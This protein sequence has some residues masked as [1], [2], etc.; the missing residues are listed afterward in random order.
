MG[1]ETYSQ[2]YNRALAEELEAVGLRHKYELRLEGRNDKVQHL[3]LEG[4][5]WLKILGIGLRKK[6]IVVGLITKEPNLANIQKIPGLV[7]DS[8]ECVVLDMIVKDR[9]LKAI[10]NVKQRLEGLANPS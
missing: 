2:L 9:I 1:K 4:R 5:Y 6:E 7:Y 10:G 3:I 8:L